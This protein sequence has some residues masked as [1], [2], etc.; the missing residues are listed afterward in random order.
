MV[1]QN[2]AAAVISISEENHSQSANQGILWPM[3]LHHV[4]RGTGQRLVLAH[5]FTQNGRCWGPLADDPRLVAALRSAH[6]EVLRF[7]RETTDV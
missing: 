7:T 6:A 3:L 5:G 2:V 4:T 1:A